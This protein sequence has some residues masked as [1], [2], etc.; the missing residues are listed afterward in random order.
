MLGGLDLTKM[1]EKQISVKAGYHIRKFMSGRTYNI[2]GENW[3][4]L[5]VGDRRPVKYRLVKIV[6]AQTAA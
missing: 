6:D 5:I 1:T 4:L 2:D 3:K